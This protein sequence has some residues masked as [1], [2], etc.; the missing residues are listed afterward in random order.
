M[1]IIANKHL[2]LIS[3]FLPQLKSHFLAELKGVCC[4]NLQ[5]DLQAVFEL[6]E[7]SKA[8]KKARAIMNHSYPAELAEV[9]DRLKV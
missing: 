9:K 8:A 4:L 5:K 6:P 7:E 3:L 2:F 1:V